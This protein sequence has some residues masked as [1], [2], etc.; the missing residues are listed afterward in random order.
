MDS[1]GSQDVNMDAGEEISQR[2]GRSPNKRQRSPNAE[3][4][5]GD[6]DGDPNKNNDN[7][8]SDVDEFD[9][10][11][12][13]AEKI[14]ILLKLATE[15][16]I[17]GS[18]TMTSSLKGNEVRLTFLS[19]RYTQLPKPA[20][21]RGYVLY[22]IKEMNM[23]D[24][25]LQ[26]QWQHPKRWLY[27]EVANKSF[28]IPSFLYQDFVKTTR[29]AHKKG[30]VVFE[31]ALIGNPLEDNSDDWENEFLSGRT[32]QTGI[33]A[34]MSRLSIS[35]PKPVQT[36]APSTPKPKPTSS[37]RL[38]G[39]EKV[40]AEEEDPIV[41]DE[42]SPETKHGYFKLF[43]AT[44]RSR[45]LERK[46]SKF[47]L[48]YSTF[49]CKPEDKWSLGS[50]LFFERFC[51]NC[52]EDVVHYGHASPTW[53]KVMQTRLA[54]DELQILAPLFAFA[55]RYECHSSNT[56]I[57]NLGSPNPL[58]WVRCASV[59]IYDGRIAETRLDEASAYKLEAD[60]KIIPFIQAMERAFYIV[61]IHR[62]WS[63]EETRR[64]II[65]K[66]NVATFGIKFM[67]LYIDAFPTP[68]PPKDY[69]MLK[70][71]C[72][73]IAS[74]LELAT[75]AKSRLPGLKTLYTSGR[76]PAA[77][78]VESTKETKSNSEATSSTAPNNLEKRIEK[79]VGNILS[80]WTKQQTML[81][82]TKAKGKGPAQ[83]PANADKT[84]KCIHCGYTHAHREE[85]KCWMN[86][87][88]PLNQIP[89][90]KRASVAQRRKNF[91]KGK[92]ATTSSITEMAE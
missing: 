40:T 86:P 34:R 91:G 49:Q 1:S 76:K 5:N 35:P 25:N 21:Q 36:A 74:R 58:D 32:A 88:I 17:E 63:R 41:L 62:R 79:V 85:A 81:L 84:K 47:K 14:K 82:Q 39:N 71:K 60:D 12:R 19:I 20:L 69:G 3:R 51:Q 61:G 42:G 28:V 44:Y 4:N 22:I 54:S 13:D 68:P 43:S 7:E 10:L 31:T 53:L 33:E 70:N 2:R 92:E 15:K 48:P 65:D 90:A 38:F 59:L 45:S 73:V 75:N 78:K 55:G 87:D 83:R 50:D 9:R 37:R 23:Q 72:K 77:E 26:A 56:I 30:N 11:A 29:L 52:W 27:L 46:D 89:E 67:E 6:E 16:Q 24:L 64:H 18:A 66:F 57:E 80:N 8:H